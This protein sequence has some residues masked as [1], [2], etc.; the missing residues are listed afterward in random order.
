FTRRFCVFMSN[1]EL[2]PEISLDLV[3]RPLKS[4]LLIALVALPFILMTTVG[5]GARWS[6]LGL[7]LF[8]TCVAAVGVYCILSSRG[9]FE[10]FAGAGA[11]RHGAGAV[12]A[13]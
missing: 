5:R 1:A 4:V 11:L 7:R 3:H 9:W 13:A 8:S 10:A 6:W 12:Y 2:S